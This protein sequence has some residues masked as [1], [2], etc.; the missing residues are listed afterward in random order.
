MRNRLVRMAEAT[1]VDDRIRRRLQRV[2][3][4]STQ[5]ATNPT[6]TPAPRAH[7]HEL[8]NRK[9]RS[10]TQSRFRART[11]ARRRRRTVAERRAAR[12]A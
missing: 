1:E 7:L 9:R 6:N 8:A 3:A 5:C 2:V 10:T 12:D 11:R 4:L